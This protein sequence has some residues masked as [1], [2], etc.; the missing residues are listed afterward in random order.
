MSTLFDLTGRTALVTGG[1]GVLGGS[2]AAALAAHGARIVVCGRRE[3]PLQKAV[4][5]LQQGGASASYVQADA[6]DPASFEQ[7]LEQCGEVHILLNAAG[8]TDPK[9]ITSPTRSVFDLD[10]AAMRAVMDQNWMG[11]VVPCI[12]VA[13]QYVARGEGVIINIASMSSYKPV[14]RNVAYSSGKA[15]AKNFTEWLAVHLAQ[16]HSPKIRVNAIAPGFFLAEQNRALLTDPATGELNDR[17]KTMIRGTP[18]GRLG[19]PDDL[20]GT[21]VFLASRASAFLTGVTIPVD[22]GFQA[23]GGV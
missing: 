6:T 2:M 17:A 13:R 8:G 19:Q 14:T 20:G 18:M 12:A 21:V 10:M 4:A 15:A 5:T 11:T 7:A 22:G 23:F 1:G 16:H 9:A 3:E